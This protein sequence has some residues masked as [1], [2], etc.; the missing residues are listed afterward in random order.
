MEGGERERER[1]R[2]RGE[3]RVTECEVFVWNYVKG[4]PKLISHE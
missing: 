1:E 3:G 2:E 4:I